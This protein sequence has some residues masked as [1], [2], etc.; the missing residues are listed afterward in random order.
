MPLLADPNERQFAPDQSAATVPSTPAALEDAWRSS[1]LFQN[2]ENERK[3]YEKYL[4]TEKADQDEFRTAVLQD[5]R[6]GVSKKSPYTLGFTQQV[7]ALTARQFQLRLQD[8]FQ[9]Y[10]SFAMSIV[11]RALLCMEVVGA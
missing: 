7:F 3:W 5:K 6:K 8:R 2:M 9:L 4:E 11:S 1:T 10:T